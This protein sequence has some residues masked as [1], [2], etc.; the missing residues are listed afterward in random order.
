[1]YSLYLDILTKT[2]GMF[3]SDDIFWD[4]GVFGSYLLT[5]YRLSSTYQFLVYFD[6]EWEIYEIF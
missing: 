4:G 5:S 6:K 2:D 1:M 3:I